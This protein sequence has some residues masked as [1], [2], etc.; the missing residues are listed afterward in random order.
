LGGKSGG[1]DASS[2]GSGTNMTSLQEA[3]QIATEYAKSKVK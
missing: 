1:S 2:Q 3:K